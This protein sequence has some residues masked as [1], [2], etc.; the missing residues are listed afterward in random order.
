[1]VLA[2]E[3]RGRYMVT[4]VPVDVDQMAIVCVV[5][6]DLFLGNFETI[7]VLE[8]AISKFENLLSPLTSKRRLA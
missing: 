7:F 1:M 6:A 2:I 8:A 4:G 5:F 3:L